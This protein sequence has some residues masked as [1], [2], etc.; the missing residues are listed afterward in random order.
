[1][2]RV[3]R[4]Y[5]RRPERVLMTADTQGSVWS[6]AFELAQV[7]TRLGIQVGLATMGSRPTR[8]AR[9]EL[10][11][12]R[13]LTLFE[14]TYKLEWMPDP[15]R[16]VDKGSEWL[17]QIE[18]HFKPQLVHLNNYCHGNLP[19]SVPALVVGH[20]CVLSW[21]QAVHKRPAPPEWDEY[22]RR[23]RAGLAAAQLVVTPT[24]AMMTALEEHYGPLGNKQVIPNG[25][26]MGVPAPSNT[27]ESLVLSVGAV[28]DAGKNIAALDAIADQLPWPV[29][30]A[31]DANAA[32]GE[33][34]PPSRVQCLGRLHNRTVS[35]WYSRAAIFA[36]PA[37]Y[38]PFGASVLEAAYGACALVLGDIA[39]LRE[40]WDGAAIFVDP[41]DTAALKNALVDLMGRPRYRQE[42]AQRAYTRAQRL[43]GCRMLA[44]YR[45]AYCELLQPTEG[46]A[47]GLL[48]PSP[49]MP[50]S[51]AA[52]RS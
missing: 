46:T 13:G 16:D 6:Y 19:W 38:E 1:M 47:A 20:S 2:K 24:V 43:S 52:A 36:L 39:S 18:Q 11:R 5:P 33:T 40:N 30:V 45:D 50:Q 49:T 32:E 12:V 7:L 15:W 9:A 23:V 22:T 48:V 10:R 31:G 29:I 17:L 8:A 44:A 14:S 25:R 34:A 4:T 28:A 3:N 35:K 51:A 21:W 42:L 27:K 37:R 41:D 26:S